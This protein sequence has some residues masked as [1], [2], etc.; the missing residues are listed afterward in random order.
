MRFLQDRGIVALDRDGDPQHLTA[1]CLIFTPTLTHVLLCFH[2]KGQFWVQVGGH[3]DATDDDD[4]V[5]AAMREAQ[6]ESGLTDL[7]VIDGVLDLDRH[8][9]G[10]AFGRCRIHW[11]VG[12]AA[13]S[14]LASPRVSEESERVQWFP[15]DAL[16][17]HM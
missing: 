11:D 4:L 10:A 12:V 16:P 13:L 5:A 14:P 9:L 7:T 1:S 17:P 6:E 8:D 3:I 2:K 15:V